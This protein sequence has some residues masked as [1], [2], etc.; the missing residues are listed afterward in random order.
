MLFWRL[1][2]APGCSSCAWRYPPSPWSR[3]TV[4]PPLRTDSCTGL[5]CSRI[6][7]GCRR[8]SPGCCS[9]CC[10]G[11]W[12]R[13]RPGGPWWWWWSLC[14]NYLDTGTLRRPEP[15]PD[16]LKHSHSC[17]VRVHCKGLFLTKNEAVTGRNDG[18]DKSPAHFTISQRVE[19]GSV[20]TECPHVVLAPA[21]REDQESQQEENSWY[22]LY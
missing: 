8:R 14:S 21:G 13:G 2:K 22:Y 18:Q 4:R 10:G 15:G 19:A 9:C 11:P 16:L 1:T 12:W 6:Y 17:T 7:W 5:T 20:P 3:P